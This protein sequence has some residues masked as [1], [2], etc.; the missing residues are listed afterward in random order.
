MSVR[1]Q[2]SL[3]PKTDT[4]MPLLLHGP[5]SIGALADDPDT[6]A[7]AAVAEG[8]S[9]KASVHKA[10]VMKARA[11]QRAATA[12]E[13]ARLKASSVAHLSRSN[14]KKAAHKLAED[15]HDEDDHE[16]DHEDDD[17]EHDEDE[18]EDENARL[19]ASSVAHLSRS[20]QKKAA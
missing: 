5:T 2:E 6:V 7:D 13:N 4:V 18:D 17:R 1:A 20:N 15:E 16:D 9:E 8:E 14:Q 19:K 10:K 11:H 12:G 3:P